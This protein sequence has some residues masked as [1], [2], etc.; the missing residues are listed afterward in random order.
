MG[1]C[2]CV[3]HKHVN[4][5]QDVTY[6]EYSYPLP[7]LFKLFAKSLSFPSPLPPDLVAHSESSEG[8]MKAVS[9]MTF[10]R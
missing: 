2:V 7:T 1:V 8:K 4:Q 5:N 3:I 10:V 6:H 9:S